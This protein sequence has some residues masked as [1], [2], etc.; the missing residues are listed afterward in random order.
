[1]VDI[2]ILAIHYTAQARGVGKS[3]TTMQKFPY[4]TNHRKHR[5][6]HS[7]PEIFHLFYHQLF[8]T[9]FIAVNRKLLGSS[10]TITND[11]ISC[12]DGIGHNNFSI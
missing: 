8:Q 7:G 11:A 10:Q 3:P 5:A 1:M 4:A 6:V 9:H 2:G 12:S